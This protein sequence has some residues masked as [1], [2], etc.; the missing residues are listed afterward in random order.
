MLRRREV[1]ATLGGLALCPICTRLARAEVI[2][3][4]YE[5]AHGPAHWVEVSDDAKVCAIGQNQSPIDLVDAIPAELPPISLAWTGAVTEVVNNGHTIQ[6]NVPAGSTMTVGAVT[7][8]LVQFHFHHPSEHLVEGQSRAM[9]VHFVHKNP[10]GGYGVLGVMIEP[11]AVNESFAAVIAVMPAT[12]GKVP[13]PAALDPRRML[14]GSLAHYRY[15]GSLT[16]PPCA[17][18]VD[19]FV[20]KAGIEVAAADI[21]AFAT[22]FPLN[23]RPVQALSRRFVLSVG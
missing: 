18:T 23:A 11:G 2:H 1:L 12:E 4:G 6:A 21:A 16:T 17:E 15:E 19:W 10:A 13:A 22:L 3:W 9:E 20:A 8:D 7:Y 5:G 14:P